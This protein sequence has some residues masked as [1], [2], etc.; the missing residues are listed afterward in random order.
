[1]GT[2]GYIVIK[3][4]GKI[5][6]VF[7]PY[8]SYPS[9]LGKY[10]VNYLKK[11]VKENKLENTEDCFYTILGEFLDF[12]GDMA[13]EENLSEGDVCLNYRIEWI[14]RIDMNKMEIEFENYYNKAKYNILSDTWSGDKYIVRNIM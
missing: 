14:Y 13:G 12:T 10:I 5:Y 6:K 9:G 11:L 8:D 3:F 4:N 1:M 7:N 2:R